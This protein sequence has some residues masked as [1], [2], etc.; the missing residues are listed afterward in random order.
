[1]LVITLRVTQ[2]DRDGL[3]RERW[4]RASLPTMRRVDNEVPDHRQRRRTAHSVYLG[5]GVSGWLRLSILALQCRAN[6]ARA[7]G[8]GLSRGGEDCVPG[9]GAAGGCG[10]ADADVEA[11]TRAAVDG[12]GGMVGLA[13]ATTMDRPRPSSAA[14][15]VLGSRWKGWMTWSAGMTGPVLVIFSRGGRRRG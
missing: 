11:S 2:R 13:M 8:R 6:L 3:P 12:Q 14:G 4:F 1:M 10:E 7:A 15:R 9:C 5:G